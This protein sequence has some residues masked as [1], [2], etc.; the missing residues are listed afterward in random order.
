MPVASPHG[1]PTLYHPG[2]G[3]YGFLPPPGMPMAP[4]PGGRGDLYH[5]NGGR[6]GPQPPP[7][8]P[9][10]PGGPSGALPHYA[11]PSHPHGEYGPPSRRTDPLYARTLETLRKLS[12]SMGKVSDQD[13]SGTAGTL[14]GHLNNVQTAILA[15]TPYADAFLD[16]LIASILPRQAYTV[17]SMPLIRP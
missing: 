3:L 12:T 11:P 16:P 14:E 1:D 13:I 17:P 10:A 6:Y 2:G 9:M 7:A 4:P 15:I 5:Y 8:A